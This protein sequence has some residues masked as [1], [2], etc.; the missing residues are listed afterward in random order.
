[1][2]HN[3]IV[4]TDADGRSPVTDGL[5]IMMPI[6]IHLA[7]L[8][9]RVTG[10][11]RSVSFTMDTKFTLP[12]GRIR[13]RGAR[14]PVT[15]PHPLAPGRRQHDPS[16]DDRLQHLR[17]SSLHP[18][19]TRGRAGS[20]FTPHLLSVFRRRAV[21]APSAITALV[22]LQIFAASRASVLYPKLACF[23]VARFRARGTLIH[24]ACHGRWAGA[25]QSPT[26]V[27]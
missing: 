5:A 8:A 1:M 25:P 24:C 19:T 18:G 26:C 27:G 23:P 6:T 9:A 22:G 16:P 12:T 2:H 13:A 21:V 4:I 14:F 3:R 20:P 11:A 10:C 15:G 7:Q 17:A